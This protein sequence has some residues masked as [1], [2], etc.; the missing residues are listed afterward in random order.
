MSARRVQ[1]TSNHTVTL[2]NLNLVTGGLFDV[3]TREEIT[4]S[5]LYLLFPEKKKR[6]NYLP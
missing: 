3:L 2:L 6:I 4:I 1:A 5:N